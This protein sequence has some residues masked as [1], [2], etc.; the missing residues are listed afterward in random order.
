MY[1]KCKG[2]KHLPYNYIHMINLEI[3]KNR[4]KSMIRDYRIMIP[5]SFL[6]LEKTQTKLV[7]GVKLE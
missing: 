4:Q 7:Q 6:T 1:Q 5:N 3:R 2:I